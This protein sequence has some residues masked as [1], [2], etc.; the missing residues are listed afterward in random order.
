[1]LDTAKIKSFVQD[2]LGCGC[3]EEVFQAIDCKSYVRLSDDVTL[4]WA[5][6]IG[7]RLL[8]YVIE[9]DAGLDDALLAFLVAKGRKERDSR[10][11]NRFRLVV[12]A[13]DGAA[14]EGLM[15]MF[16]ELQ[17]R[18]EKVHLHVIR[19]ADAFF[20]T[21]SGAPPAGAGDSKWRD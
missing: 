9:K 16:E 3:P 11:L 19:K 6:T 5:I 14:K 21:T 18:D 15:H 8:I 17:D 13:D 1:M 12:A 4:T 20:T 7:G 2:T 10:G